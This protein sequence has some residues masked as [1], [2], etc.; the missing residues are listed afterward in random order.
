MFKS[1]K[2][3]KNL[4]DKI[5]YTVII[6]NIDNIEWIIKNYGIEYTL[7]V[8]EKVFNVIKDYFSPNNDIKKIGESKFIIKIEDTCYQHAK[9]IVSLITRTVMKNDYVLNN[10][11]C[12]LKLSSGISSGFDINTQ[13][14]IAYKNLYSSLS[15]KI[16]CNHK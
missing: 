9:M 13:I 1:H 16:N 6:I 3:E 7:N 12:D 2:T 5:Y 14:N 15:H 8:C 11:N 10:I 4:H